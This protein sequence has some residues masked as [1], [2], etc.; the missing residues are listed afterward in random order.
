MRGMVAKTELARVL[1]CMI[2]CELTCQQFY[3][4]GAAI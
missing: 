2:D 1:L 3:P 4:L